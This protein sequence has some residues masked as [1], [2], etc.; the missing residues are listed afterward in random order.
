MENLSLYQQI[1]QAII[2]WSND[3]TKTAG[4]LT[5]EIMEL[6]VKNKLKFMNELYEKIKMESESPL[7]ILTYTY[8]DF[9]GT[10]FPFN[11]IRL[12]LREDDNNNIRKME[13]VK[14]KYGKFFMFFNSSDEGREFWKN[15]PI[16]V[17]QR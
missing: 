14:K 17:R 16:I 10:L 5:R 9:E 4:T 8:K 1:E 15:N 3:G 2:R 12:D 11:S 6:S 7:I 13:N